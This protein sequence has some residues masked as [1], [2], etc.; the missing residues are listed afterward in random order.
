MRGFVFT[1]L[2]LLPSCLLAA[3]DAAVLENDAIRLEVSSQTGAITRIFDKHTNTEY[4]TP[5]AKTRLFQLVLPTP[6]NLARQVN[7][8]DQTPISVAV[9]DGILT[10]KFDNLQIR[11]SIYLFQ[12]EI[13][14][15]LSQSCQSQRP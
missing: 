1:A 14:I 15:L 8:T 10:I 6:V 11:Q 2:L 3:D 7:S 4:M 5:Q 9:A 13:S 12:A